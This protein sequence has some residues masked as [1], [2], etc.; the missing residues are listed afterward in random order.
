MKKLSLN[1]NDI[2]RIAIALLVLMSMMLS[3]F[4]T[5]GVTEVFASDG[6]ISLKVG[7][8]IDYAKYLTH[9]YYA[10]DKDNPV[11][12]VQPQLAAVSAGTYSYDF[13]K[14]DSMLAKCLYY[15]YGGPGFSAYTEK[16]LSGQWDGADDAYALTHI[17]SSIA[18]DKNTACHNS[19]FSARLYHYHFKCC[20]LFHYNLHSIPYSNIR[21]SL[22]HH[23]VAYLLLHTY[24]PGYQSHPGLRINLLHHYRNEYIFSQH[25]CCVSDILIT[26][27]EAHT[28]FQVLTY[29]HRRL[30][31]CHHF[32]IQCHP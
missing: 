32:S 15:G 2:P 25:C 17:V 22:C 19:C 21:Y 28:P 20:S 4:A 26:Q 10:G 1:L 3:L 29:I 14:P 9:Y 16:K 8:Q 5:A 7:K 18:Y 31:S 13:I 11:Y 12:C 30:K 27:P 24:L 23:Q 6:S